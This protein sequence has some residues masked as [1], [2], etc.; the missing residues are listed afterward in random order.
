MK[1]KHFNYKMIIVCGGRGKRMGK[2]TD[3]I[4]KPLI[5][6]GKK[7]IIEHKLR[8]YK[9]QGTLILQKMDR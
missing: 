7:T 5:K 1:I 4:P 8:Y 3:K 6:I 2:M 9:S